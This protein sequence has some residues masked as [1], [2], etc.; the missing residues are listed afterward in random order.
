M[1][2]ILVFCALLMALLVAA[3]GQGT[4]QPT[5]A[6]AT[7]SATRAGTLVPYAGPS[8]T[9]T[10]TPTSPNTATPLP[11]ATPT[12]RTHV[13]GKNE[14]MWGI[15][16][17]YGV[18]L[19]DLLTA[20]PTVNPRAMRVG[21]TLLIP[22]PQSTPTIDPKHPPQPTPIT[23]ALD[24]PVCQASASGGMWCFTSASSSQSFDVE[25]VS[26]AI[27]LFDQDSGQISTQTAYPPLNRLQAGGF[28]PLAAYF[29]PPAPQH[30]QASV[31]LVTALPLPAD[32]GRYLAVDA[33]DPQVTIA[34]DGLSAQVAG[35]FQLAAGQAGSGNASITAVAFDQDGH[36]TGLRHWEP[37]QALDAG[38]PVNYQLTVYSAGAPINK[39]VVLTEAIPAMTATPPG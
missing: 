18:T 30:F 25:S 32:S 38:Q 7:P 10:L 16:F 26:V 22:A 4:V 12:P 24:P 15:A 19:D 29:P 35:S 33:S 17:A 39:V 8:A 20:N 27:H 23:L 28:V 11:T 14:D 31:E 2:K 13:V 37:A 21:T 9:L 1:K 5:Q 6:V 34:Q 3:C 36:I